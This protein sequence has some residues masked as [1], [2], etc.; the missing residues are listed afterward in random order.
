MGEATISS[1]VE[2]GFQATMDSSGIVET[3][4]VII[5]VP[6]PLRKNREPDLSF[7]A[8]ATESIATFHRRP[9]KRSGLAS[10]LLIHLLRS[11]PTLPVS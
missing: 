2:A 11:A 9:T 1:S 4:V 7:V 8:N 10:S 5:C 6:T 3:D